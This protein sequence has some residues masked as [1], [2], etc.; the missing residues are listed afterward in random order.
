VPKNF[1]P[2]F[3][4][5][6][7][8]KG[9]L[10]ETKDI[11]PKNRPEKKTT[12]YLVA[13]TRDPK[14]PVDLDAANA[15]PKIL[16]KA[17]MAA[18]R[19][20]H[21]RQGI[22]QLLARKRWQE[23]QQQLRSQMKQ[24]ESQ[25]LVNQGPREDER[26][27]NNT[28]PQAMSPDMPINFNTAAEAQ[29]TYDRKIANVARVAATQEAFKTDALHTLY[30]NSRN[31]ITTEEQLRAAVVK[32]FDR[33]EFQPGTGATSKSMWSYGAPDDIKALIDG[34][35]TPTSAQEG[36]RMRTATDATAKRLQERVKRVAEKLSGGKI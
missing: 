2:D 27:T 11:F 10:P 26:L 1:Q 12:D 36:N 8:K 4:P 7:A 20:S 28:V 6:K 22:T 16:Y 23:N 13:L 19:R 35:W 32:E 18:L 17:R 24:A 5:P 31:F 34:Q 9:Y 21:L 14:K 25:R 29:A 3:Y 30:M 33:K 15:S